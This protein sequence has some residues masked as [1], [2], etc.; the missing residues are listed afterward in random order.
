MADRGEPRYPVYVPSKGRAGIAP[1]FSTVEKLREYAIP[2]RLVVEPAQVDAYRSRWPDA[3]LLVTPRDEMRLLGTRNFIADHAVETGAD[4]HWQLDDNIKRFRRLYRRKRLP[5]SPGLALRVC[6]DFTDR[7]ENIAISGLNYQMFVPNNT[8]VP[9]YLNCHVYSCSLID[10]RL[11]FRWRAIYNDDTD[12]CLQVLAAGFCTVALNVYMADKANTMLV[13]GGNTADLYQADGRL[14]MA[15]TLERLWPHVVDVDRRFGRPQH[16]VRGAWRGFD[17]PL[18]RRR[19]V[20][21][22]SLP[23][24]DEYDQALVRYSPTESPI[25]QKA[26]DQWV[27]AGG[28]LVNRAL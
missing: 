17:Q 13:G 9:F 1:S 25:V 28:R 26:V 20:D 7:Y 24:V 12:L 23:A 10:H 19:D 16:V 4:R 18:I 15:R 22:S 14:R 11:P 21:W 27:A 3:D 6:E 5:C 2:F 8:A